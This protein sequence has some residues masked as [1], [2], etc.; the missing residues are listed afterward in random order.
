M[1]SFAPISEEELHTIIK[2]CRPT[3]SLS[4]HHN[5]N[6]ARGYAHHQ[7]IT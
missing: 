2:K 5:L 4:V 7:L 6:S 1:E 3:T